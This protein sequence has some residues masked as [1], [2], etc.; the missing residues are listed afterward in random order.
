MTAILKYTLK[1]F[2]NIT[3]DGFD[4]ALPE[5]TIALISELL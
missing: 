2:T 5:E 3:F 1:D 4:F